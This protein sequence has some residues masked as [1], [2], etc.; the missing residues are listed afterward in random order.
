MAGLR[1]IFRQ[2]TDVTTVPEMPASYRAVKRKLPELR[3]NAGGQSLFGASLFQ[4]LSLAALVE[5]QKLIKS[6]A[7]RK[8][9]ARRR[10]SN[11]R[12]VDHYAWIRPNSPPKTDPSNRNNKSAGSQ[13]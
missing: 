1:N 9:N 5:S 11:S 13:Q 12:R 3:K 7:G 8:S 2:P 4:D 6:R 10:T